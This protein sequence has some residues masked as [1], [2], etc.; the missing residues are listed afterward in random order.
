MIRGTC[1]QFKFILP[2][3][4]STLTKVSITFWQNDTGEIKVKKQLADCVYEPDSKELYVTLH[5][6][7]TLMFSPE[8]KGFAQLRGLTADGCV[9]GCKEH[10]F[11][12]YPTKDTAILE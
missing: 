9:F 1:Q 7:E 8:Y 10:I 4:T 12:V 11:S 5:Q 2:Y 3:K 6:Q